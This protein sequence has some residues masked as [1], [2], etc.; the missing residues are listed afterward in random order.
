MCRKQEDLDPAVVDYSY[1]EYLQRSVVSCNFDLTATD[2]IFRQKEFCQREVFLNLTRYH[3]S[4]RDFFTPSLRQVNH[5]IQIDEKPN[6]ELV[7]P[8]WELYKISTS[9]QGFRKFNV[10]FD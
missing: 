6:L 1:I 10:I 8:K 5:L 2:K 4:K 7:E 3:E 9:F